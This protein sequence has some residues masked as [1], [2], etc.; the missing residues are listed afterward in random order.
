MIGNENDLCFVVGP[1]TELQAK[2][3][4]FLPKGAE[5]GDAE[6]L[7][8]FI[9]KHFASKLDKPIFFPCGQVHRDT[10]PKVLENEGKKVNIVTAYSSVENTQL[11]EKLRLNLCE[12]N[13]IPECL[14]FFSPS[15]VSLTENILL[16]EIK[17]H[18]PNIKLVAMGRATATR[19][20]ELGLIVSAVASSPKPE[21]LL[22]ALKQL[23]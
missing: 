18:R 3:A 23:K 2:K 14:V 8:S 10:L 16:T 15:G 22:T 5:S 1:S 11:H 4:G 6:K 9:L 21:S 13:P 17:P 20:K 7:T 12:G 19:L